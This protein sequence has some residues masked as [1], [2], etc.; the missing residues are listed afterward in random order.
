MRRCRRTI[1]VKIS[2]PSTPPSSPI[3]A[4]SE[5]SVT[6]SPLRHAH[7]SD[8]TLGLLACCCTVLLW[9][10]GTY[11]FTSS[12]RKAAATTVN[13]V[14][15]L[16]ALVGM[17]LIACVVE[18]CMPWDLL[19]R[20]PL[21]Q[22]GWFAVSG[23]IGFTIGDSLFFH[24]FKILGSRRA[25]VFTCFAPAASLLSGILLLDE[26]LSALGVLGMAISIGGILL[27]TLSKDEQQEVHDDGHGRFSVGVIVAAAGAACQGLGLVLSRKGFAA[28]PVAMSAFHATFLRLLAA[29]VSAY[30]SGLRRVPLWQELKRISADRKIVA[31]ILLGVLVGPILGVSSSLY[32][33]SKI[34]ASIAQTILA[35]TPVSVTLSSAMIFRERVRPLSALAVAISLAGVFL[36][37]WKDAH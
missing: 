29:T 16:Y 20:P 25:T 18:Q 9:T 15:L 35:L 17:T 27:L 2:T 26:H 32:A 5:L 36:L 23:L 33:V 6:P 8:S 34:E 31:P 21:A 7:M 1:A 11:A 30:L 14:R 10:I 12:A 37:V 24:A 19:L 28:S 4:A 13:R 3:F 22:V